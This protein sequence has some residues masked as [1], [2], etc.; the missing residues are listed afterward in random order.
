MQLTNH[1]WSL[2]LKLRLEILDSVVI[3]A[4]CVDNVCSYGGYVSGF[5]TKG[6]KFTS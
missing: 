4:M 3:I 6:V 2:I 5:K 1:C